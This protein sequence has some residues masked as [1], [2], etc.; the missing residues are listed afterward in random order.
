MPP[1][2]N[3]RAESRRLRV[4]SAAVTLR[5]VA[6][7]ANVAQSTVLRA[8]A[9]DPRISVATRRAVQQLARRLG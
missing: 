2:T 9:A 1:S 3:R 8:L 4:G 6:R 5:D 7:A